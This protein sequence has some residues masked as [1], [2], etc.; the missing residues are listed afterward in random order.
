[1]TIAA[2]SID[3]VTLEAVLPP[4]PSQS[5]IRYNIEI[6][7]TDG[8]I[9]RLPHE[10]ERHPFE[11][12]FV[13]DGEIESILPILWI[14]D[15]ISSSLPES[16]NRYHAA[17]TY[18][19]EGN[20]LEVFDGVRYTRSENGNKIKFNKG[21]EFREDRTINI[22][23]EAPSFSGTAGPTGPFREY[24]GF[25]F[26]RQ[27]GILAPRAD[28]YRVIENP[29][30]AQESHTQRLIVQQINEIFLEMNGRDS[31]ADLYKLE[32]NTGF[33]KHT[34]KDEGNESIQTLLNAL[35]TNLASRRREA[36]E[37]YLD[38]EEF[39][40]Y[41]VVSV[42]SSNWDGFHNNNWMYLNPE[43]DGGRWEIIPWDL[44]KTW[45]FTDS[46]AQ[47]YRMPPDFPL[48]GQAEHGSRRPGDITGLF[49]KDTGIHE[50]YLRRLRVELNR[51]FLIPDAPVLTEIDRDEGILL[52]DLALLE[53]YLN[54]SQSRRRQ[55]IVD[56]YQILREFV[57][58]RSGYLDS[59]L[60]VSV[61]DWRL[62]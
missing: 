45:G 16:A 51:Q 9:L 5:L 26:Y 22:I 8:Q 50:E 33:I 32:H 48:N 12:Y 17:V 38:V 3:S 54:R 31:S 37:K 47:F 43:E 1:M 23:P 6:E 61:D 42:L 30:T 62:Y 13:F 59:V 10:A 41:S 29:G 4:F 36:I 46:N 25:W 2:R 58:L 55:Q 18:L 56:S 27:N 7:R 34:N 39:L 49:H 60:P 14:Y 11:S 21:E 24:L 35:N 44:D 57:E 52:D 15:S 19:P 28:W 53:D 20:Q 40:T